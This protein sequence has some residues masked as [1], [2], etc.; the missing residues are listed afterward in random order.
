MINDVMNKGE[1]SVEAGHQAIQVGECARSSHHHAANKQPGS[2][3]KAI[4][5]KIT[6]RKTTNDTGGDHRSHSERLR[7]LALFRLF[8][9]GGAAIIANLSASRAQF[10]FCAF[11]EGEAV[12][13][14]AASAGILPPVALRIIS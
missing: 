9:H 1:E 5:E 4:V 2:G 3:S 10:F 6:E 8:A 7:Q 14:A 12:A 13:A 11:G